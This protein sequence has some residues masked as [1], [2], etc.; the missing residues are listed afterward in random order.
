MRVRL[1]GL[2]DGDEDRAELTALRIPHVTAGEIRQWCGAGLAA[3]AARSFETTAL[4]GFWVHLDAD[5]LDPSVMPAVD[6]PDPGGLL[7]EELVRMLR[8]LLRSER[9]AGLDVTVYDPDLD[10]DGAAGRLLADLVVAAFA[11]A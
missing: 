11:E 6:S 8:P 1:F 9:C 3:A 10:P 7:A 5:V 4:D 2:R